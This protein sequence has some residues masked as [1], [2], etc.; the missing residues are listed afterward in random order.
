MGTTEWIVVVAVVG[1]RLVLPL[2]IPYFPL[3]G[4]ISCLVLDAV[5]QSI[6]Q[7]FPAIPLEG[8]QS[9]DKALDI[10]YLSITYLSTMRNWTNAPAFRVSQALFY[11]RMIGVVAFELTQVRAL[12]L[13]FP[14]TFEYFFIFYELVRARWATSRLS[15]RAAVVAA[16]V[17][18]IFV[19]LPQE[20]WIHIAQLDMTDFIKVQLLGISPED[21]WAAGIANA[22][23]VVAAAATMALVLIAAVRWVVVHRLPAAD[24]G[25]RFRADPLPE[26]LVG[27]EPYRIVRAH[28]PVIGAALAEKVTLTSLL[29]VIFASMLPTVQARPLQIALSVAVFVVLNASVSHWLARRGRGAATVAAEFVAMAGVNFALVFFLRFLERVV[30]LREAAVPFAITAFF[31]LLLTVVITLF[32]RYRT[33]FMARGYMGRRARRGVALSG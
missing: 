23:F 4:V 27:A 6:F 29:C 31:V 20:W 2:A 21:A 18:W 3:F 24:H 9:Y 15:A 1:L 22:P 7:Q 17:I 5:D 19:K 33:V 11:Y 26:K 10:Y 8:Y 16:A 30:D 14:N 28:T 12:L 32:D 13:V 25:L